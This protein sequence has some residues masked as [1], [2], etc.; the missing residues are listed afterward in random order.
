MFGI[1]NPASFE[2]PKYPTTTVGYDIT[3][4]KGNARF[5]EV[6]LNRNGESN[7]MIGLY[8]DGATNF[9][10]PLPSPLDTNGM[11]QIYNL[12]ENNNKS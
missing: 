6:V 8:F 10:M 11:N 2:V 7:G 3:R 12:I 1:T 9:F 5:L 4:L